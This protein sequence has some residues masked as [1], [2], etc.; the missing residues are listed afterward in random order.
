MCVF[1]KTRFLPHSIKELVHT[2]TFPRLFDIH[3]I[4]SV[5]FSPLKMT[6]LIA[7]YYAQKSMSFLLCAKKKDEK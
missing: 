4:F 3:V 1:K 6:P 5:H 7:G 2:K